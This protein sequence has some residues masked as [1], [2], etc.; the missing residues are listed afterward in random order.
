VTTTRPQLAVS[1]GYAIQVGAF[2]ES[3]SAEGLAASLRGK[4]FPAQVH[5]ST[6]DGRWRV[7]VGPL[8]SSQEAE[9]MASRLKS[10]ERLPTW[11]LQE[12][13]R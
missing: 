3:G 12:G 2:S 11:V 9:R 4:G 8:G 10:E 6:G 5:A 7:R 13:G 1:A